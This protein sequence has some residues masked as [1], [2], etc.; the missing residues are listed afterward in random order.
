M[1]QNKQM[2][3]SLGCYMIYNQPKSEHMCKS[4]DLI[5]KL[6]W[7]IYLTQDTD[8]QITQHYLDSLYYKLFTTETQQ[9]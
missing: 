8:K 7:R 6:N 5:H 4:R 2:Q 3:W 9:Q 1:L